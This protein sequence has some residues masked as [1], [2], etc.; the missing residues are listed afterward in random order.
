M[1]T[2]KY[3]RFSL[4]GMLLVLVIAPAIVWAFWWRL[5]FEKE[6]VIEAEP[7]SPR[8]VI[9]GDDG[10]EYLVRP[11]YLLGPAPPGR[12]ATSSF[13]DTMLRKVG[14]Y[15]RVVRIVRRTG[16]NETERHGPTRSYNKAGRLIVEE[17]WREGI[18][19][20]PYRYW[21][22][23]GKL[24]F[25]GQFK[26]GERDGEWTEWDAGGKVAK[27]RAFQSG[28][29][30][31]TWI[32]IKRGGD[33][34]VR[35]HTDGV[36]RKMLSVHGQG[37]IQRDSDER[38]KRQLERWFEK[39]DQGG[40]TE[41]RRTEFQDGVRHGKVIRRHRNGAT[42][43]SGEYHLGKPTGRWIFSNADRELLRTCEFAD[44]LLTALNGKQVTDVTKFRQAKDG[45]ERGAR[46]CRELTEETTLRLSGQPFGMVVSYMSDLHQ[47]PFLIDQKVVRDGGLEKKIAADISGLPLSAALTIMLDEYD[48]T[49]VYRDEHLRI[50]TLRD[51]MDRT[52]ETGLADLTAPPDMA[53]ALAADTTV[54]FRQ[55]TLGEMVEHLAALHRIPI[56]L[57][58]E[59]ADVDCQGSLNIRGISLRSFLSVMFDDNNLK[60]E[61]DGDELVIKLR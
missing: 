48:W 30:A 16:R 40:Y 4:R 12:Q 57:S 22:E 32:E 47:V 59:L 53:T 43:T 46:C 34:L 20:G 7:A 55:A 29:R 61:L 42:L 10:R 44:G 36:E 38:G 13:S 24:R 2:A 58:P 28:E 52:D 50:T 15:R 25:S 17:S 1:S 6:I 11:F 51:A 18:L 9:V 27:I 45:D 23:N 39:N 33:F 21:D 8:E 60:C 37:W 5:P 54:E 41:T 56:R 31:G 26:R 3:L 14:Y 35:V 19:H 49:C